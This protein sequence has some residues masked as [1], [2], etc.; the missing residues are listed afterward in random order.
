MALV[1][2]TDTYISQADAT[3]YINGHYATTDA[4]YIAWAALTSDNKDAH[5]RKAVQTIDRQPLV[6]FKKTTT[7]ALAFPRTLY[8]EASHSAVFVSNLMP[9]D[10][11]YT[12]TTTPQAILDAQCE[13]AISNAT[14][15]S[16]RVTL[17]RQGVK[18]F[19][20]GNLSESLTGAANALP[21]E[22]KELMKP[23]LAG[24]VRIT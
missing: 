24:S 7:Q 21:Y 19:S 23:Y 2:D 5:L 6:G 13:I 8:T 15:T 22:A 12:Q 20:I 4:E 10:N 14:G 1:V 3:T 18:S 16:V 11:W 9:Y 17:Q